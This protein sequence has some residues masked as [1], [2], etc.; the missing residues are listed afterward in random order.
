MVFVSTELI[1]EQVPMDFFE[2]KGKYF[3]YINSH[4]QEVRS[5]PTLY[6]LNLFL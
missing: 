2:T 3:I 1:T 6:F 5:C 4:L